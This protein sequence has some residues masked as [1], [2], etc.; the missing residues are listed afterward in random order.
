MTIGERS[1]SS[2]RGWRG[3]LVRYGSREE[4]DD[5]L[6]PP[7]SSKHDSGADFLCIYQCK[8]IP[9]L[10]DLSA[11]L[12]QKWTAKSSSRSICSYTYIYIY[13]YT[14]GTLFFLYFYVK[15]PCM[16]PCLYLFCI[17]TCTDT[18]YSAYCKYIVEYPETI[19]LLRMA[20]NRNSINRSVA[21]LPVLLNNIISVPGYS[22]YMYL[23]ICI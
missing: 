5:F 18:E 14:K 20:I 19:D 8:S 13:I 1:N 21:R 16:Y 2:A 6:D 22:M 3:L 10:S 4:G 17:R 15:V 9:Y 11:F 23:Y 12:L 7:L